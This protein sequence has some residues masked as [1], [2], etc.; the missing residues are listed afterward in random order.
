M[1]VRVYL[2]LRQGHNRCISVAPDLFDLDEEGF[3]SAMGDWDGPAGSAGPGRARGGRSA[4]KQAI[5]LA[6]DALTSQGLLGRCLPAGRRRAG[7][8]RSW[9]VRAAGHPCLTYARRPGCLAELL[10]GTGPWA[11]REFLFEGQ[12]RWSYGAFTGAVARVAA[13]L[14]RLGV[15]PGQRVMLLASTRSSGL[16]RS[17][18]RRPWA[19]SRCSATPGGTKLRPPPP[20]PRPRRSWCWPASHLRPAYGPGPAASGAQPGRAA[21]A[22]GRGWPAGPRAARPGA[23]PTSPKTTRP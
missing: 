14:H 22:G 6:T 4:R 11:E 2:R 23:S 3:A 18:P 17:G 12:R 8:G 21:P 19:P 5:S 10:R 13:H 1:K 16:S 9:P 15:R 20:W 7:A